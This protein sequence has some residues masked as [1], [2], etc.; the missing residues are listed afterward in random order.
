MGKI[1]GQYIPLIEFTT[2]SN[3]KSNISCIG[4][5]DEDIDPEYRINVFFDQCTYQFSTEKGNRQTDKKIKFC[6]HKKLKGY[7]SRIYG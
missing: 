2:K 7:F 4:I 1:G 5:H 6:S 3:S